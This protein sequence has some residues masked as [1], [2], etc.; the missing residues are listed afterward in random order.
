MKAVSIM[1]FLTQSILGTDN[2]ESIQQFFDMMDQP[3]LKYMLFGKPLLCIVCWAF[4]KLMTNLGDAC[5]S[6][7]DPIAKA[8]TE[9]L[10]ISGILWLETN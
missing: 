7:T 5:T 8:V 2:N 9:A 3:P 6:V 10:L 1:V 4:T